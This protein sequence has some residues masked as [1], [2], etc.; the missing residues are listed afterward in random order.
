MLVQLA[1][2]VLRFTFDER[3]FI[4]YLIRLVL[5]SKDERLL[6][7]CIDNLN[8][9]KAFNGQKK[10]GRTM[11]TMY[12]CAARSFNYRFFFL[13]V[14]QSCQFTYYLVFFLLSGKFSSYTM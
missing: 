9:V 7:I 5:N 4:L 6:N 3:L 14:R 8:N 10:V 11:L 13:R 2:R 12:F 1:P